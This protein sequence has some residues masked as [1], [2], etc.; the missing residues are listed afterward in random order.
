MRVGASQ[1]DVG[2]TT[3]GASTALVLTEPDCAAGGVSEFGIGG[4]C[5]N[6]RGWNMGGESS[7]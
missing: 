4:G 1:F 6:G 2:A 7:G 5:G 3:P